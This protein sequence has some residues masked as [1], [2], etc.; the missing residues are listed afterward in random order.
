MKILALHV[1]LFLNQLSGKMWLDPY[2]Q[3]MGLDALELHVP[4][5][6]TENECPRFAQEV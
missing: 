5:K 6:I 2:T 1:V 3:F 4:I